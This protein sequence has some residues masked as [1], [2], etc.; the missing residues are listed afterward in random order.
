MS[1]SRDKS[2]DTALRKS[3]ERF[4]RVVEAAP[5]AMVMINAAGVIEMVNA[6]AERMFGYSRQEMLGQSMEILVPERFRHA[7]PGLRATFTADPKSR[8]MGEGRDLNARRKDG[9][10]FPVE[11]GLNPMD[12]EDGPMVLSAIVDIS[13]RKHKEEKIRAALREKEILLGE[14]HHR[15]KNNL[16]IVDSLLDLQLSKLDDPVV[17]GMLRDSQSRIRSMVLIHQTLYQSKDF[18]RVDFAAFLD[19]LVPNLVASYGLDSNRISLTLQVKDI[20][21]PLST[22]IPCGLIVNELVTNVFKHAFPG[23]RRGEIRVVLANDGDD[24][25]ALSVSDDGIGLPPGLDVENATTLGLQLVCLLAEQLGGHIEIERSGPT[26]FSL[27][28]PL[29]R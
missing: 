16:Q 27:H 14:V 24:Q 20:Q 7:H 22:A 18:A 5:N 12:T 13:D 25:V 23:G 15:V 11:I 9:S 8:P 3:E 21:L 19:S 6:Q 26:R 10:E 4:R 17:A 28:F 1:Q 29:Q 2:A